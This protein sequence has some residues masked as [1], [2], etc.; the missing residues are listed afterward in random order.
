VLIS[1]T[2]GSA[3]ERDADDNKSLAFE[4]FDTV[5][6]AKAAVEAAC[7]DQVSCADILTIATR[8]AISMVNTLS[9]HTFT[10]YTCARFVAHMCNPCIPEPE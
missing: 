7:P 2:A 8:D 1:S 6:A 4:G 3:A 10:E 5:N 9:P